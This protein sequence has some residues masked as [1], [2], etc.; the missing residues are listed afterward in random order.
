MKNGFTN[1]WG[2]L[3]PGLMGL[4]AL[5]AAAE[6]L[7]PPVLNG[8]EGR[9]ASNAGY[10]LISWEA[11]EESPSAFSEAMVFEIEE[12]VDSDFAAPVLLYRGKDLSKS[13]SGAPN[14][15]FFYRARVSDPVSGRQ[16]A[17]SEPLQVDVAHHSLTRAFSFLGMGAIVFIGTTTLIF[18]GHRKAKGEDG[19]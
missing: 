16:S 14:G 3:F 15:T 2:M 10:Y 9:L 12:S 19:A 18:A 5:C 13:M 1:R 8:G 6:S 11:A 4:A 17:W 7:A